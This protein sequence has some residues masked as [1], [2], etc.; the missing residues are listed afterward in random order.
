MVERSNSINRILQTVWGWLPSS[1]QEFLTGTFGITSFQI[2]ASS[3]QTWLVILILMLGLSILLGRLLLPNQIRTAKS[4][5][6][7]TVTPLGSFLGGL[8][9]GLNGFLIINLVREYLDG[10]NLPTGTEAQPATEVA[11]AGEQTIGIVSSGVGFEVTDLPGFT[12]VNSLLA[13]III[14][15]AFLL[16]IL[17]LRSRMFGLKRPPGYIKGEIKKKKEGEVGFIP[18]VVKK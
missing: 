16:L 2:D 5:Y 11:V 10:S 9:G 17:V 1:F 4:Y 3:A 18:V 7:Y 8:L 13:W 14:G 12:N 15:F 6:T